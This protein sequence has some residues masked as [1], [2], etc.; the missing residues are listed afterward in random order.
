MK[1]STVFVVSSRLLCREGLDNEFAAR[2]KVFQTTIAHHE[3]LLS[4]ALHR[5]R[6]NPRLFL[7]VEHY[8]S[9]ASY[10]KHRVS[11]EL[12]DW[13]AIRDSYVEERLVETWDLLQEVGAEPSRTAGLAPCS[14]AP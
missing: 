8:A 9:E 3:G 12:R 14:V 10:E 4:H 13:A 5:C 1:S 7:F 6:S 2:L 11:A